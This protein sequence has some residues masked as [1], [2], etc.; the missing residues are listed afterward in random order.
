MAISIEVV[1]IFAVPYDT[2]NL[3]GTV[4][5]RFDLPT[6]TIQFDVL[7]RDR[8]NKVANESE[9]IRAAKKLAMRLADHR[10]GYLE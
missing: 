10:V 3:A 9:A 4:I 8:G 5:V 2:E 6:E 1:E 7:F